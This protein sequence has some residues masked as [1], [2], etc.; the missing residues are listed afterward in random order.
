M[1]SMPLLY[2][3]ISIFLSNNYQYVFW[4]GIWGDRKKT[5]SWSISTEYSNLP[6]QNIRERNKVNKIRRK[7]KKTTSIFF[8]LFVF[9]SSLLSGLGLIYKPKHSS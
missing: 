4:G 2:Q 7:K 6:F 9:L 8:D 3:K 1:L 5:F